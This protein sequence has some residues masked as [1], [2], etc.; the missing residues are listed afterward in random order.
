METK[1]L[2][3]KKKLKKTTKLNTDTHS[4]SLFKYKEKKKRRKIILKIL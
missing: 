4:K 1:T 2:E 3:H